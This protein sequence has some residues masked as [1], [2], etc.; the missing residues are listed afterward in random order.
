MRYSPPVELTD[1]E[2]MVL[3]SLT[4]K[5][6]VSSNVGF[7]AQIVLALAQGLSTTEVAK[8]LTTSPP[9]V[10]KWRDRYLGEGVEG[11]WDYERSG[12]PPVVDEAAVVIATMEPPPEETGLTQWSSRELAK[13]MGISHNEIASIW[14]NWGLQP[15]RVESF[16]FSTDPELEAK[17]T[18]VVGLY[19]DPP[20][21]AVVLCVD[22]KSQVQAL[23]RAQP[24]LP[25]APGLAE[26]RSYDYYRH[27]ITSLFAALEIATGKVLGECYEQHTNAEFLAF[28]TLVARQYPEGE[29]HLVVDNYGTHTPPKV[30]AWLD[31]P[32]NKRITLHVTPTG[33]SWLNL[34]EVFFSI[35]TR[36]AIRR[37]SFTSVTEL[38]SI[39]NFIGHDNKDCSPFAWTKPADVIITKATSKRRTTFIKK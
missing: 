37:G 9:T 21:N 24:M 28:L 19:L 38:I 1:D 15:H 26:R 31:K 25:I 7:R 5:A 4:R 8:G 36:T 3:V 33:C 35:I 27:G 16:T 17:I 32:A 13:R 34:V 20:E 39:K 30:R 6:S 11:W 2:R 29:L 18:D 10:R 23:E 12:R 14:R 22:E